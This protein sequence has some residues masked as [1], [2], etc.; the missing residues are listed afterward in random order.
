MEHQHRERT[1]PT[2]AVDSN[3]GGVNGSGNNIDIGLE[4]RGSCGSIHEDGHVNTK[5][6]SIQ[7][8]ATSPRCIQLIVDLR[9]QGG[10]GEGGHGGSAKGAAGSSSS[11]S[12]SSRRSRHYHQH[13]RVVMDAEE[14]NHVAA[15]LLDEM[16]RLEGP[17]SLYRVTISKLQ[18]TPGGAAGLS[19][20]LTSYASTVKAVAMNGVLKPPPTPPPTQPH[21][22]CPQDEQ[23]EEDDDDEAAAAEAA[24]YDYAA[25]CQNIIQLASAFASSTLDVLNLSDNVLRGAAIWRP[26][27]GQQLQQLL[28]DKVETDSSSWQALSTTFNWESLEDLHVVIDQAMHLPRDEPNMPTHNP[29][30]TATSPLRPPG[31]KTQLAI[32]HIIR[33]CTKLASLRWVVY[34]KETTSSVAWL[35]LPGLREMARRMFQQSVHGGSLRHLVLEGGLADNLEGPLLQRQSSDASTSSSTSF[36]TEQAWDDLC[37]ALTDLPRLRTLKLRHVGLTDLPIIVASLRKSRPPLECLDLSHNLLTDNVKAICELTHVHKTIKDMNALV[38]SY[39]RID[40]DTA[41]ELIETFA[42]SPKISTA[43]P[44]PP[45]GGSVSSSPDIVPPPP[46]PPS[47][48]SRRISSR[49]GGSSSISSGSVSDHGGNSVAG[50][51]NGGGGGNGGGHTRNWMFDLRLD[52]NPHL[53]MSK[54]AFALAAAKH[55]AEAECAELRKQEE[56]LLSQALTAGEQMQQQIISDNAS[57]RSTRSTHSVHNNGNAAQQAQAIAELERENQ[58]LMQERDTLVKAFSIMGLGNQVDEQKRV[59]ERLSRLEDLVVLGAVFNKTS[60]HGNGGNN[61]GDGTGSSKRDQTSSSRSRRKILVNDLPFQLERIRGV[62]SSRSV[63]EAD[64]SSILGSN[65]SRASRSPHD[66]SDSNLRNNSYRR[67]SLSGYVMN[68]PSQNSSNRSNRS[69]SNRSHSTASLTDTEPMSP[70]NSSMTP[71]NLLPASSS[72]SATSSMGR[73]SPA[74][75]LVGPSPPSTPHRPHSP[76]ERWDPVAYHQQQQQQQ[77]E[78]QRLQHHHLPTQ[79]KHLAQLHRTSSS[80]R[81]MSSSHGS[82][83]AGSTLNIHNNHALR[84]SRTMEEVIENS[85]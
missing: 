77:Q 7:K 72:S 62:H 42:S 80:R 48:P 64:I 21:P 34:R 28:L 44:P 32:H 8:I 83:S 4:L 3:E 36:L 31:S 41:R 65:H 43:P 50:S 53:Q 52:N 51:I 1:M 17:A 78:Q 81:S 25:D 27:R 45:T 67:S 71:P 22:T 9:M 20:F 76:A 84:G 12:S 15:L 13:R 49:R 24:D 47:T 69:N 11:K 55:V 35:P 60:S 38:L 68:A 37:T 56:K 54:I 6:I 66:G 73:R 82:S 2:S 16:D 33:S 74:G 23:E 61:S 19:A 5:T 18:F 10:G 26:W 46:P 40:T 14:A 63:G 57:V 58:R 29:D 75:S 30:G 85:P 79:V 70:H 39:N 59:L